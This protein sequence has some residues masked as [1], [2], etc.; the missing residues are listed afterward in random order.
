MI[1]S[2]IGRIF[3]EAYNEK[4]GT[5]YDA[6]SFFV[7]VYYPLFYDHNKYMMSPGNNPLEN[8]KI[9]WDKMLKGII[10]YETQV[11]RQKRFDK[12][13][14]KVNIGFPTTENAIGFASSDITS[15][16][17]SQSS[18]I[19]YPFGK[20]DVFL[21]WFGASLGIGVQGGLSILF[22]NPEILLDIFDGWKIYRDVLNNTEILKGNQVNTWNGQWLG[23][24]YGKTYVPKRPMANFQPFDTKPDGMSVNVQSWTKVLIGISRHYS[25]PQMM[26]Y[27][28]SLGQTNTTVG[29]IPFNLAQIRKPI[30]FYNIVFGMN[31]G[32]DAEELWGTETGFRM[33]CR[34]GVIG[35][36]AMEPKGLKQ[37]FIG[38]KMPKKAKDSQQE[39]TFNTYIIWI[40]AMLNNQE[41]WEKSKNYAQILLDYSKSGKNSKT[42]NSQKVSRILSA[43]NKKTFISE[44]TEIVGEVA[45][46]GSIIELAEFINSM[47]TDNVPYFLTLLRFSYA[48]IN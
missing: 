23:H 26:G 7:E 32:D 22:T 17:S 20:E 15:T 25:D 45:S 9:S 18:N 37:Y 38:T 31:K 16:T 24:I 44:L 27:V 3:L 10:P 13:M 6:K 30:E 19:E 43:T 21:S 42:I 14:E 1:T 5:S 40:L 39:V 34:A 41:L 8:P 11:Q 4:N 29:F 28:Y 47:P 2:T 48:A 33:S 35:L 46:K 36:K 12:L